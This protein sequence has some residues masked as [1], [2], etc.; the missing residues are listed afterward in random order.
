MG[1]MPG[2]EL[3]DVTSRLAVAGCVAAGE[4][5]AL[6]TA[7]A[8]GDTD[9]LEAL[10]RR[11]TAGEP[12]AWLVG[13]VDFCG[14]RVRVDPGVYVP[15]GQTEAMALRAAGLL[16]PAGM[17]VDLCTG[18][19]AL[20][21][22]LHAHRPTATVV[23][24]D[25]DPA[26]VACARRNDIDARLGSLD[27]PLPPALRG[28]VDV[29]TAV[30]PYVPT[31]ELAFLPR[32]AMAYEP[33]RALDG[34]RS[35][36]DLLLVVVARSTHWLRPGGWLLLELGGSQAAPVAAGMEAAG[37]SAIAVLRD[38]EGDDRAIEGTATS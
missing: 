12:L 24:T 23:A 11:R 28:Q 8:G 3:I 25:I 34:G 37:F 35:G 10:V 26:A 13:G 22:V 20:P 1:T 16:P 27:E 18:A 5:A 30:V 29:L 7:A 31:K 38:E 9:R 21:C 19:G 32:D 6:L 17:A 14:V 2:D 4:E 33:R 15:R 36:L